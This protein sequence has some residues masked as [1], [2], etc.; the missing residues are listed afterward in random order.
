IPHEKWLLHMSR[1][2]DWQPTDWGNRLCA[3]LSTAAMDISSV[4]TRQGVIRQLWTEVD[5]YIK[6]QYFPNLPV[7]MMQKSTYDKLK[8]LVDATAIAVDEWQTEFGE[9]VPNSDPFHALIRV[10]DA[11]IVLDDE[12]LLRIGADAM[13]SW[14]YAVL[15]A[16]RRDPPKK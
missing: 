6:A 11:R 9:S 10:Q 4:R 14:H 8:R 2:L 3:A 15:N 7:H 5:N 13:Y 16:L 12:A 1:S